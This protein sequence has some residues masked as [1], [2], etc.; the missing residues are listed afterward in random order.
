MKRRAKDHLRAV[1]SLIP[2]LA[3]ELGV[4]AAP[5]APPAAAPASP[6]AARRSWRV[7]ELDRDGRP[8]RTEIV[9]VG[10]FDQRQRN[11]LARAL[12]LDGFDVRFG[13]P[14]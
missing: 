11:E 3:K 14:R 9:E 6:A 5:A 4:A 1:S 13:G 10:R 2:A 7:T 8:L 12:F